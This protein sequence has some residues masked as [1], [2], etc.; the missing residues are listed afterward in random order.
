MFARVSSSSSARRVEA[1]V[2]WWGSI[3][4]TYVV[5]GRGTRTRSKSSLNDHLQS[6]ERG[7]GA[8]ARRPNPFFGGG[9]T[10][11]NR[12]TSVS[13]PSNGNATSN[14]R[15]VNIFARMDSMRRVSG[16][17]G[18]KSG[19]SRAERKKDK[20][21]Y[22]KGITD[23]G[24]GEE[25]ASEFIGYDPFGESPFGDDAAIAELFLRH[26]AASSIG[27]APSVGMSKL[28]PLKSVEEF[29]ATT[30][31]PPPPIVSVSSSGGSAGNQP[32]SAFRAG[33]GSNGGTGSRTVSFDNER[34]RGSMDNVK[35]HAANGERA[36]EMVDA[37]EVEHDHEYISDYFEIERESS[38]LETNNR[39]VRLRFSIPASCTEIRTSLLCVHSSTQIL[40]DSRNPGNA[41]KLSTRRLKRNTTKPT[42]TETGRRRP[43]SPPRLGSGAQIV[44][45]PMDAFPHSP[46][47]RMMEAE[48]EGAI[49]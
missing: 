35:A 18:S 48:A 33:T 9:R 34:G 49:G 44:S 40:N 39:P 42:R 15:G 41:S 28:Q 3:T 7:E 45:R 31:P 5:G 1:P 30:I 46:H 23:V 13:S 12:E 22:G 2:Q 8:A 16:G 37:K 11:L 29:K 6:Y 4:L 32:P 26:T 27:G 20:G 36:V 25:D 47:H 43:G 38:V 21:K 17:S 24:S 19:L 10:I 14:S